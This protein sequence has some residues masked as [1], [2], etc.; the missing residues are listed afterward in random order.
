MQASWHKSNRAGFDVV[1]S[2]GK[3]TRDVLV[4]PMTAGLARHEDAGRG[5]WK[6]YMTAYELG[7]SGLDI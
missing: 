6:R 2:T 4:R 3:T 5:R 7:I 1:A